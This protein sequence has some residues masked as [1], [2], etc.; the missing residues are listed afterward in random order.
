M[1]M[2]SGHGNIESAVKAIKTGAFDF[3]QK[4]FEGDQLVLTVRRAVEHSKL[5][6]DAYELM[7]EGVSASRRYEEDQ[8][9]VFFDVHRPP[10]RLSY[11]SS[12]GSTSPS[13]ASVGR[14]LVPEETRGIPPRAVQ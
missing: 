3:I 10:S 1:V 2:F 11:T 8:I 7:G 12:H 13:R 5:L 6:R 9:E 14:N 4:P